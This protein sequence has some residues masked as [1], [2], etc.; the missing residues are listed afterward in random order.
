V[1]KA[2]RAS[3]KRENCRRRDRDRSTSVARQP[4]RSG[5]ASHAHCEQHRS[6][7]TGPSNADRNGA[8]VDGVGDNRNTPFP[9]TRMFSRLMKMRNRAAH[10]RLP[11]PAGGSFV[12][13]DFLRGSSIP[14]FPAHA[15]PGD[16]EPRPIVRH[17]LRIA[18]AGNGAGHR[19]C[20]GSIS[21][22]TGQLAQPISS[23][24][25]QRL[26]RTV[27]T[28]RLRRRPVDDHRGA[29]VAAA[30]SRRSRPSGS[31]SE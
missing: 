1:D 4:I 12:A 6:K 20:R 24:T 31:A 18:R 21:G 23:S 7:A 14:T 28:S 11:S 29:A 10:Q 2:R 13:I 30:A 15:S 26:S 22:R 9:Q 16:P 5:Q 25:R 17:V 3:P 8:S 27:G 19:G